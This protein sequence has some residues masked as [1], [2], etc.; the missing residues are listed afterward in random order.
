[1]SQCKTNGVVIEYELSGPV[2]GETVLLIMGLGAQLIGWPPTLRQG[3]A[4][5]GYQ[6]LC[7]DHRDCGLSTRMSAAGLPDFDRIEAALAACEPP[8]IAY[9][10]DDMANDAVGLLDALGIARVH[11]VGASMGGMIAQIIAADHPDRVMSLTSIM[12]PAEVAK[13]DPHQLSAMVTPLTPDVSLEGL[14]TATAGFLVS[15]TSP[16]YPISLEKLQAALLASYQRSYYPEGFVR[17]TAAA[18]AQSPLKAKRGSIC[19]PT[20]I[21]HGGADQL[22]PVAGALEAAKA[23]RGAQILT[24]AG[25]AHDLPEPLIP[26]FVE[27]ITRTAARAHP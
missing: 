8:P 23:I 16:S 1:M 14:A 4:D 17:Q 10:L 12:S 3:L 9:S 7:F 18:Y 24:L 6:V 25:W 21:L 15:F 5:R 2:S 20:L 27:Q 19:A 26:L 11:L 22:A 13:P